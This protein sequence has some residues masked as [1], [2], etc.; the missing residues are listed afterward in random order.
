MNIY[1][2][3]NALVTDLTTTCELCTKLKL[4]GNGCKSTKQII[5]KYKSFFVRSTDGED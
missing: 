2:A 1:R 4:K 3:I 5:N